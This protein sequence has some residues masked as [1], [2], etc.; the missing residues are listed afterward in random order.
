MFE[1]HSW[2]QNIDQTNESVFDSNMK[3]LS[4]LRAAY[5]NNPIIGDLN[6]NSLK[7]KIVCLRDN[8]SSSKIDATGIG[9]T[10]L[11]TSFQGNLFNTDGYQFPLFS[12]VGDSKGDGKIFF[13]WKD[14]VVK[15]LHH[16]ES[17]S[18]ESI[19]IEPTISKRKW[20]IVF[21]YRS[22]ISKKESSSKKF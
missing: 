22:K 10:K 9:E 21:A 18:I 7:E 17:P 5:P 6:I 11:D 3:G 8:I 15:R 19:C 16:C 12:K 14:I 1:N 13:A 2:L 20:F 4:K